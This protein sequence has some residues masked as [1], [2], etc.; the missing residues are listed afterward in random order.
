MTGVPEKALR[1]AVSA[2]KDKAAE[3]IL[4]LWRV[5]RLTDCCDI[6]PDIRP[7]NIATAAEIRLVRNFTLVKCIG[8]WIQLAR[9]GSAETINFLHEMTLISPDGLRNVIFN[10]QTANEAA[11]NIARLAAFSGRIAD[12]VSK[13]GN[14]NWDKIKSETGL[15][16]KEI[17]QLRALKKAKKEL[18]PLVVQKSEDRIIDRLSQR[19]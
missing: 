10:A 3:R 8:I 9:S 14:V 12:I 13:R 19:Q 5:V 4:M 18:I 7:N 2:D 16:D 6:P 1:Y 17:R 11:D 15:T